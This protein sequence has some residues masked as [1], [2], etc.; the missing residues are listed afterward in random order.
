MLVPAYQV[1]GRIRLN[2]S[3][4]PRAALEQV[5]ACEEAQKRLGPPI[6]PVTWA[7]SD[8]RLTVPRRKNAWSAS[9]G[10]VDWSMPVK[11]PYGRGVLHF[12]GEKVS[13]FWKLE[14]VL[15]TPEGTVRTPDC[16]V[17]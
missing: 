9:S 17:Q 11:G 2:M 1:Y 16:T 7:W 4:A 6:K 12:K 8:G 13:G 5:A 15:E 3:G 14:S 10:T